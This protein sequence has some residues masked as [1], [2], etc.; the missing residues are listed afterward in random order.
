MGRGEEAAGEA[1]AYGRGGGSRDTEEKKKKRVG[2]RLGEAGERRGL[3][4][5]ERRG[6]S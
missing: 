2:E 4:V 1:K 3:R 5:A 6:A